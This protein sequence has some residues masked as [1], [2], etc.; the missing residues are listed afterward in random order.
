M[1]A[2][3][4][5]VLAAC[6]GNDSDRTAPSDGNAMQTSE[7]SSAEEGV[8]PGGRGVVNVSATV[9]VVEHRDRTCSG[10]FRSVELDHVTTPRGEA[11][12]TVDGTGA[13]AFVD[14]L[15]DDGRLDIVL[16]NLSGETSIFWNT[17]GDD[18]D[19]RFDR[20][21]LERGRFRQAAAADVDADGDRDLLLT[22][23]IGPPVAFL[24]QAD[25]GAPRSFERTEYRTRVVA[26]SLAPGDLDGDGSIEVVTGSYNA[27][28][29]QNRDPRVLRGVEIGVAVTRPTAATLATGVDTE[30]LT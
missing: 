8:D 26:Y 21:T 5:V 11:V 9:G 20:A 28:L 22:T 1:L 10:A 19:L 29:T 13:G 23:G 16:P 27:E 17:T 18:G 14:D 2:S 12:A 25:V 3:A 15:D 30:F 4:V 7:S 6:G 24:S